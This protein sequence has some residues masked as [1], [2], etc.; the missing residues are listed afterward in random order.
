MPRQSGSPTRRR[1]LGEL[2]RNLREAADKPVDDVRQRLRCSQSKIS[3]IETGRV[4][5]NIAELEL[6]LAFYGASS[7]D[8]D[9][10]I[11]IWEEAMEP[12]AHLDYL[13]ALPAR[14]RGYSRLEAEASLIQTLQPIVVPGLLQIED[15]AVALHLADR[16]FCPAEIIDSQIAARMARQRRLTE[17]PLNLHAVIGEAVIRTAVGGPVV[18]RSQ[19][20]HLL[21]MA[22][23]PNITIQVVPFSAGAYGT[24]S[25]AFT[26]LNFADQEDPPSVY[27]EY[28]GGGAWA[29][30]PAAVERFGGTFADAAGVA[31]SARET[32]RFVQRVLEESNGRPT[33]AQEQLQRIDE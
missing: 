26:I 25:G 7:E 33:V 12:T 15:Y 13:K 14:M 24:M 22:K 21:D 16:R 2:L 20:R 4:P 17:R 31:L 1:R 32:I 8:R 5:V 6:L 29:E 3:R 28:A 9:R 10:A 27:L 18:Q 23:R 19:L 30:T 11:A